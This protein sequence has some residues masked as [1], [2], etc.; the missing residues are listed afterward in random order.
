MD[1]SRTSKTQKRFLKFVKSG[2]C[3]F[4][5]DTILNSR[6]NIQTAENILW[7]NVH[8]FTSNELKICLIGGVPNDFG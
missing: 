4:F 7:V 5:Y 3:E 2:K 6:A 1:I 8:R